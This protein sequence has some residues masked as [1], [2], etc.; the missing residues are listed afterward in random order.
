MNDFFQA[1]SFHG[2]SRYGARPRRATEALLGVM[3]SFDEVP[4]SAFR[5][6][7]VT[8]VRSQTRRVG[9]KPHTSHLTPRT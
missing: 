6:S 7:P 8:P 1:Q 4:F 3:R 2:G 9:S 5:P